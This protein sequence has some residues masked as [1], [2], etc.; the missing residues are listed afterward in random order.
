M[1]YLLLPGFSEKN[2][3]WTEEVKNEFV[4]F[5]IAFEVVEW[6]HWESGNDEDFELR[7]EVN[8]VVEM[9]EKGDRHEG[10]VIL[11]KSI[12]SLVAVNIVH[13]FSERIEK[14]L[15]MGIPYRSLSES[16]KKA[17]EVLGSLPPEIVKVLQNSQDPLGSYKSVKEFV[18]SIDPEIEV[19]MLL[20]E[21]HYYPFN[22][23]MMKLIRDI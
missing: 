7:E 19:K 10:L 22:E 14:L 6:N 4:K 13:N 16:A 17:F 21:D 2:K 20:R 9:L 18:S 15:L 3:K 23:V 1:K 5:G 12:G 8:Q 11:A